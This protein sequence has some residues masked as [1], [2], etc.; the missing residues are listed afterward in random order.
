M[1]NYGGF[2]SSF[3]F[4]FTFQVADNKNTLPLNGGG[5]ADTVSWEKYLEYLR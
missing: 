3:L 2:L 1:E 4:V 5:K